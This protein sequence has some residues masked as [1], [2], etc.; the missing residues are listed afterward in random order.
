MT[1]CSNRLAL[2]RASAARFRKLSDEDALLCACA[3]TSLDEAGVDRV[4]RLVAC[5]LDWSRVLAGASAHGLASLLALHL[6]RLDEVPEFVQRELRARLRQNTRR[7]VALAGELVHLV[8]RLRAHGVLALPFKGPVLAAMAYGHLGLREFVDLDLLVRTSDVPAARRALRAEGYQPAVDLPPA[9]ESAYLRSRYDYP[10]QRDGDGLVVEIHWRI[11][12]AHFGV[13]LDYS[14]FWERAAII[15]LGGRP[16]HT[17]SA[18]DLLIVLAV[19]GTKHLWGRLGWVSD[20]AELLHAA[21][22][23]DW[24][25]LWARSEQSRSQRMLAVALA[26]AVDLLDAPVPAE[27]LGRASSDRVVGRLVEEVE[28]RLSQPQ[29]TLWRETR[30]HTRAHRYRVDRW[31]Y[32]VRFVVATTPGDWA[33]VRLPRLL[34]PLYHLIRLVRI[35]TKYGGAAAR[36]RAS[37]GSLSNTRG[38]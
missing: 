4:R 17:L 29:S 10:F 33:V 34:F 11:V 24:D 13:R 7:N 23:L 5:P 26:L 22:R 30:F 35:M 31:R 9:Q 12:P 20:I 18:E 2:G 14:G 19:H 3:R 6:D 25:R 38:R 21:Q 15:S 28:Q 27:V 8:D 37:H 1:S 36:S 16:L 32:L